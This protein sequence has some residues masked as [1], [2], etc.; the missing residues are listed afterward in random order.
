MTSSSGRNPGSAAS[1]S[2]AAA[3]IMRLAGC[4]AASRT[5]GRRQ[6]SRTCP[7]V[8]H[9]VL[10]TSKAVTGDTPSRPSRSARAVSSEPKPERAHHAHRRDDDAAQSGN[11]GRV[12]WAADSFRRARVQSA[13]RNSSCCCAA[14]LPASTRG[15]KPLR[16]RSRL[17]RRQTLRT[18]FFW[19]LA[20]ARLNYLLI[21][22]PFKWLRANTELP[23]WAIA[24]C[25]L[26]VSTTF[27]FFGITSS[28]SAPTPASA[29]PCAR[30]VTAVACMWA[31]LLDHAH[32]AQALRRAHGLQPRPL[33]ARSRHRRHA[34][35]L[36]GLK[37][38]LYHKW[39][40]PLPKEPARGTAP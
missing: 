24:A 34:V 18:R 22:T 30:Y 13:T 26:G 15:W 4:S 28:I 16:P 29:T 10:L 3:I 6:S 5:V 8:L 40:F 20:G 27:F 35:L 37:F 25:S 19:F 32:G 12:A 31:A 39:V 21:A 9:R 36:S 11:V 33:P 14:R 17:K 38:F 2:R 1:A 23:I 7:A